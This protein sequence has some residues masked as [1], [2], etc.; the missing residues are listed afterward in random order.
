VTVVS[1]REP[2]RGA[3]TVVDDGSLATLRRIN[4][5]MFNRRVFPSINLNAIDS[6]AFQMHSTGVAVVDE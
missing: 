5:S 4:K 6:S 2:S 1:G 3:M